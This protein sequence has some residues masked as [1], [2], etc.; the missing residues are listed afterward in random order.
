MISAAS[1]KY[2][3]DIE[4]NVL[5]ALSDTIAAGREFLSFSSASDHGVDRRAIHHSDTLSKGCEKEKTAG[6]NRTISD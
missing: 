3:D 1:E 4:R 2:S 5:H 6:V